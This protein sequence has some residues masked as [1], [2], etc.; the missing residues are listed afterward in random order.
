MNMNMNM[1]VDLDMF[2]VNDDVNCKCQSCKKNQINSGTCSHCFCC[3]DGEKAVDSC[4][5]YK[6]NGTVIWVE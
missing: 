5:E 1:N 3:I 6:N 4:E 2:C